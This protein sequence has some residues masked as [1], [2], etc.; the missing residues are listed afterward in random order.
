MLVV[1]LGLSALLAATANGL[2]SA[3]TLRGGPAHNHWVVGEERD[4]YRQIT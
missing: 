2:T 3:F 4:T 1:R